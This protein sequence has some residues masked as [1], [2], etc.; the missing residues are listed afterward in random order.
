MNIHEILK[1]I[2]KLKYQVSILGETIS[3]ETH[4]VEALIFSMNWG[5]GDIDRAH[6]IFEKY[7]KKLE[8]GK[9]INWNEFEI[10][11]KDEFSIGY[12]T[13]KNI[14]LAFYDNHQWTDVCHGYALSFEPTTPVEFH[15]ITRR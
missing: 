11:L 13:V 1:D 6:D 8:E 15:R 4:P 3:N 14:V 2:E 7:D 10:E 5:V 12:Q 9:S